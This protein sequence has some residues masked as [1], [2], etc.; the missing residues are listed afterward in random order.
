VLFVYNEVRYGVLEGFLSFY[1]RFYFCFFWGNFGVLTRI[2]MM[3]NRSGSF[4][5]SNVSAEG[6]MAVG[7]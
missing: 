4:S 2:S 7:F 1:V 3:A 6:E 5:Q